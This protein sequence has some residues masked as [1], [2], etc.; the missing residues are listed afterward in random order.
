MAGNESTI[1]RDRSTNNIVFGAGEIH[2]DLYDDDGNLTGERYIGSSPGLSLSA[3]IERTQTYDDDGAVASKIVDFVRTIDRNLQFQCKNIS[4]ENLALFIA[5]E[6]ETIT[7]TE[8]AVTD[9]DLG[10]VKQ[11]RSYI[12]GKTAARPLGLQHK[13]SAVTVTENGGGTSFTESTSS[14][15]NAYVLDDQGR[16]YIEVKAGAKAAAIIPD[17]TELEI[18][19]T[20]KAA[21]YTQAKAFRAKQI[22]CALH[23]IEFPANPKSKPRDLYALDCNLSASGEFAVKSRENPQ[24]MSFDCAIQEPAAAGTPSLVITTRATS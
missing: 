23:Y 5:G 21:S 9:E 20:P 11:G 7:Y 13:P 22:R 24:T 18:D 19:Y 6:T 14:V 10:A 2:I 17:G 4:D 15:R 12:I 16:I 3:Q 8:T 1:A